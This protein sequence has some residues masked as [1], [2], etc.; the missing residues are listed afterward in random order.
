MDKTNHTIEGA[1]K[2]LK[3]AGV[4]EKELRFV[5]RKTAKLTDLGNGLFEVSSK[6]ETFV[7]AYKHSNHKDYEIVEKNYK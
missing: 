2:A 6:G 1:R 4:S 7:F 3:F 5:N